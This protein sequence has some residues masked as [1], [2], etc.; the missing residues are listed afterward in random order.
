MSNVSSDDDQRNQPNLPNQ[1]FEAE[2]GSNGI[3]KGP[4]FGIRHLQVFLLFSCLFIA[5]ALRVNLSIGIVAMTDNSTN[6][7]FVQYDWSESKRGLILSSFFWGYVISQVPAGLLAQRYGPKIFLL[8]TA[9]ICSLLTILTP[10]AASLGWKVLCALR[11]LQ[12]LSQGFVF[13]S[14]HTSLAKWVHPSERGLLGT[15]TYSGTQIGTVLML[16]VSGVIAASSLGWPGIFYISGALGVVWSIAFYIFGSN[17]PSDYASITKD[18]REYIESMPGSSNDRKKVIPW[19]EIFK[20]KPFWALL[21]SHCAQ[22]WG[23]WTLLTQIPSYMK[24]TLNFDIK[25]NAL[26]SALPYLFMWILSLACSEISDY[27][28]RRGYVSVGVGRKI[29]NSIGLWTPA[30]LLIALGYV[31]KENPSLAVVLLTT[32]IAVNSASFVGYLINH[33]DL[34]P[35][36]AGTLMGLTNAAANVFSILGPM[37]VGFV[38]TDAKDPMLWRICFFVAAGVFFFGNLIFIIFGKGSIQPWNNIHKANASDNS[39]KC[40]MSSSTNTVDT[41]DIADF[42]KSR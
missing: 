16:A 5:Y 25:S 1:R 36:F 14:V 12:G 31:S 17:S 8:S 4:K 3:S 15:F 30:V 7:D 34:S 29:F 19:R 35:N 11:V 32:A 2:D 23:F 39:D 26:L 27:I 20:S 37:F 41:M 24:H 40:Q 10:V 9:L 28:M 6:P 38:V 42:E 13:P 33:M 21:I 18:E 22:N